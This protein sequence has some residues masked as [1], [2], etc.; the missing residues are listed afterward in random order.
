MYPEH[1]FHTRSH[2]THCFHKEFSLVES[3]AIFSS[4]KRQDLSITFLG[5]AATIMA[6]R[7][8]YGRGHEAGALLGMTRN[9]RRWINTNE[10][11]KS[12]IPMATDVVFLWIPFEGIFNEKNSRED[13]LLFLGRVIRSQLAPHLTSVHYISSMQLMCDEYVSNLKV[14]RDKANASS[15]PL[16]TEPI[17]P[18]PPG[19]SPQGVL[20]VSK[21]VEANGHY[22]ER[23]LFKHTGRQ[24]NASPWIGLLSVDRELQ[25]SLG[26]DEKYF[27]VEDMERFIAITREHLISV[28]RAQNDPARKEA[29]L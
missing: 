11:G 7:E 16:G 3:N 14:A 12:P 8:M 5:A 26:F 15:E 2:R 25:L 9:A 27:K 28:A 21:R 29:K 23:H 4:L 13:Q 6:V 1:D 22:I 24:V 18:S 19:F 20:E 10:S 17:T